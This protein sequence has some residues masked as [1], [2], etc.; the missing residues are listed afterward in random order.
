M[1][2][3]LTSNLIL[4]TTASLCLLLINALPSLQ[5]IQS[6]SDANRLENDESDNSRG[7][8]GANA[9]G[10][11]LPVSEFHRKN[12]PKLIGRKNDAQS[13][14]GYEVASTVRPFINLIEIFLCA[15]VQ[16]SHQSNQINDFHVYLF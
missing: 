15:I 3:Q 14:C 12:E 7:K 6:V 8:S 1:S 4:L 9:D 5:N 2:R 11:S 13:K 16:F 10:F